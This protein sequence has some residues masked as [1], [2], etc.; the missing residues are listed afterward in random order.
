MSLE[1][2]WF[3]LI[4]VVWS[5]YFL[6]EGFDFGVGLLL[7]VLPRAG[8]E[9]QRGVMFESIGPVWDGNEVWLVIA[10]GATFAAFPAWYATMFSGFYIALLLI[11][12]LLIVRAVSFEWREKRDEPRWR[13]TWLWANTIGSVGATFLWG[14][15]LASLVHGVPLNSSHGFAG[16]FFDL[17]SA[18]TVLGGIAVVLLFALHGANYLAIR[19]L[20]DLCIRA[21]A[22]ARR[23]SVLAALVGIAFAAW[24]VVV[25]HNRNSR[26]ILPTAIVAAIATAALVLAVA[27]AYARRSGWGFAMTGIATIGLVA[28]IFTG[29]YPRVL[30]SNPTF[31]NSLTISNA[32]SGHY[33]LKV[34]TIVAGIF[35][36]LML[37]YQSW[38][39][40]VFRRR[41][42]GEPVA[43]P[44]GVLRGVSARRPA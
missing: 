4:G 40:Y 7:P 12:V 3:C 16:D 37:L 10:A 26:G 36:P 22:A 43:T 5:G 11:L 35:V 39:Y 30:V 13:A 34:I 44:A 2:F 33:A 41:L 18:Y 42:G 8:S 9:H 25:A 27:L 19:T 24:T 14:V 1:T 23:L 6:L 15:I 28:T 32:A 31:A 17:F 29:L 38:T 21:Q 20:G